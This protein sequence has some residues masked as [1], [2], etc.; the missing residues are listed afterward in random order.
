MENPTG[1]CHHCGASFQYRLL[2]NGFNNTAYAYCDRCSFTVLLSEW[3]EAARRV[4][5]H[6]QRRITSDLERLLKPCP[7]GGRFLASADPKCPSCAQPLSAVEATDYVEK[8]A[9]GTAKGWRWDQSWTGVYS[10]VINEKRVEDWWDEQAVERL[11]PNGPARRDTCNAG[12]KK[13][14]WRFWERR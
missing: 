8:N 2:H 14:W 10:I 4:S 13:P 3:S 1:S 9:P 7:C 6:S 5:F 12:A 11:F